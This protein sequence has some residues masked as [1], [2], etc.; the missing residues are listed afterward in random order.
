MKMTFKTKGTCCR[1][2]NLEVDENDNIVD[3]E[4]VKGCPGNLLGI[5]NM[6]IGQNAKD[7]ADRLGGI[8]CGTK[9]TSCPDQLS[10]AINEFL[11]QK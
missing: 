1:E 9:N 2:I 3:V 11:G 10:Q 5:T 8:A 6:V 4:F 7:V